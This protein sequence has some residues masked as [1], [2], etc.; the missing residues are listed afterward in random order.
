[1]YSRETKKG[2]GLDLSRSGQGQEAYW[3]ERGNE[4]WV[5]T[6]CGNLLNPCNNIDTQEVWLHNL[7]C[8][9]NTIITGMLSAAGR[10]E[11]TCSTH[12]GS[13][14]FTQI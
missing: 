14:K 11:R 1:M 8:S 7:C 6:K 10:N 4:L 12:K 13:E 2:C 9:P 5:S 3:R